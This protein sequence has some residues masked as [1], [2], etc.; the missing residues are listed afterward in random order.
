MAEIPIAPSAVAYLPIPRSAYRLGAQWPAAASLQ[1]PADWPSGLYLARIEAVGEPALDVAFIVRAPVDGTQS[2]ILVAMNDTT[3]NAYN[4]W[5]GRSLYGFG[6]LQTMFWTAPVNWRASSSGDETLP[7]GFKVSFRRPQAAVYEE[8][9]QR[10]TYWEVPFARWLARQGIAVEWCTMVDIHNTPGLLEQYA[11]VVNVGH[12]EYVS[13]EMH[14]QFVQY[15]ARG[16][17]AAFFGGNNCFWRVRIEDGGDTL[18][19]YKDPTFD[20]V[21]N[22]NEKTTNWPPELTAQMTGVSWSDS[23]LDG[24][25]TKRTNADGGLVQYVV[26]NP[27]HWALA[28]TSMR[29]GSKFGLYNNDSM[30][31]VGSET[32]VSGTPLPY[33]FETIA[34]VHYEAPGTSGWVEIATMAVITTGGTVFTA[35]T[36]DWTLGLRQH[37]RWGPIDQITLNVFNRLGS[38]AP[39]QTTIVP[40]LYELSATAATEELRAAGLVPSFMTSGEWVASQEPIAGSI[41]A[42]GTTVKITLRSGPRP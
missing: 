2:K 3:Y 26:R 31:V 17:N 30:T 16:G 27:Y 7:W 42:L 18:V 25:P 1:V 40:E 22:D 8:Y 37:S 23:A 36:N 34:N 10:W 12:A 33:G 4:Y 11:L 28:G 39:P 15:V 14:D 19:C 20:P 32:D 38:G 13:N 24:D 6:S 29:Y 9:Q 21:V 41:V 35:S 5:G